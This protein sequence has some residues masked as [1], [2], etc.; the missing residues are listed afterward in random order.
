MTATPTHV[1]DGKRLPAST[2]ERVFGDL[3][4]RAPWGTW[5]AARD[6]ACRHRLFLQ[7]T[8][9]WAGW[10]IVLVASTTAGAATVPTSPTF[11]VNAAIVQGCVVFGSS[12]QTT[13]I[14]FGSID[15]GSHAAVNVGAVNAMAGN[16]MGGQAQLV[17]TPGTTVQISVNGGQ[18]PVGA[19]RRMSNGAGKFI[20]YSLALVQGTPTLLPPNTPVGIATDGTPTALPVR[21]TVTLPGAGTASG[22]YSDN[23]QVVV[24]W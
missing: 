13:G 1:R 3:L 7:E 18:Y 22:I 12:S 9:R 24:S 4:N 8:R 5:R 14:T 15:F 10:A 11:S 6:M 16:S 19:Q 17:C 21:G 23:V 2:D 20:P